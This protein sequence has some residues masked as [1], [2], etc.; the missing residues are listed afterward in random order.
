[1]IIMSMAR[2]VMESA[3]KN[4]YKHT[5]GIMVNDDAKGKRNHQDN[6]DDMDERHISEI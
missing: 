2:M 5:M 6:R 1:M 4:Y 3:I